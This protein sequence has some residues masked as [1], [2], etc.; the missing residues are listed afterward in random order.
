MP[1]GKNRAMGG[2][3]YLLCVFGAFLGIIVVGNGG[4]ESGMW[5]FCIIR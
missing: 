2:E 4:M 5:H 1:Y 3:C